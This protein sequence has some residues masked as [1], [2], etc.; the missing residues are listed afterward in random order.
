VFK[1]D[2]RFLGPEEKGVARA[3]AAGR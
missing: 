2:P 1:P 3:L